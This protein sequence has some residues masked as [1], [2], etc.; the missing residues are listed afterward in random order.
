LEVLNGAE[1]SPGWAEK[2]GW[3]ST[4]DQWW[5][6]SVFEGT[7]AMTSADAKFGEFVLTGRVF[8]AVTDIL[9]REKGRDSAQVLAGLLLAYASF[10]A[11]AGEAPRPEELDDTLRVAEECLRRIVGHNNAPSVEANHAEDER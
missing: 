2:G 6:F 4:G 10:A 7:D 11:S 8:E 3:C 1:W 9:N 5:L